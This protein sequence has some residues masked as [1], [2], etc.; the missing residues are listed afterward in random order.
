M[1]ANIAVIY[2]LMMEI[3]MRPFCDIQVTENFG[4]ERQV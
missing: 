4:Y 2:G 1:I 3:G